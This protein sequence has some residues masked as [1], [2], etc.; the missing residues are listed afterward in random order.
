MLPSALRDGHNL[1]PLKENSQSLE[2][3]TAPRPQPEAEKEEFQ[4]SLEPQGPQVVANVE[5]QTAPRG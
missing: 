5:G 3:T 2:K 4:P 1:P